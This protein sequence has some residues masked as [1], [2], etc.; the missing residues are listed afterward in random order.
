MMV[1]I[2][3]LSTVLLP[4]FLSIHPTSVISIQNG[5]KTKNLNILLYCSF[6]FFMAVLFSSNFYVTC[7]SQDSRTVHPNN[8]C[9]FFPLFSLNDTKKV[10]FSFAFFS[11]SEKFA[12]KMENDELGFL[13]K[14]LLV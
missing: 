13:N 11:N 8:L 6:G 9:D 4:S 3:D 10:N 12:I 14:F 5:G 7:D 1:L 2:L